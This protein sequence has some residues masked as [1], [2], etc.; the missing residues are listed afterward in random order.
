M[1]EEIKKL[2]RE[3]IN[4]KNI[5]KY[6]NGEICPCKEIIGIQGI[7]DKLDFQ[8]P[9]AW[10]GDL[11]NKEIVFI[12]SNPSID[13][14][15]EYP[16]GKWREEDVIDFF[17]NR[18]N[19]KWT[20]NNKTLKKDGTFALKQVNFWNRIENRLN[21]IYRISGINKINKIGKDFAI[22]EIVRCKSIGENGITPNIIGQCA[23]LY[24][25][26]TLKAAK[27]LKILIVVGSVA[28][29][30]F[31]NKFN[32]ENNFNTVPAYFYGK[33]DIYGKEIYLIFIPHT[34]ARGNHKITTDTANIEQLKLKE[35][36]NILEEIENHNKKLNP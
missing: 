14:E 24:L 5:D 12:S 18:F 20:K 6:Y 4:C 32:L 3:L 28:R 34:N 36:K 31:I 23:N 25:E 26:K 11:E 19:G 2:M 17:N 22:F 15:E 13:N 9:E 30:Y 29:N 8:L 1:D 27:S 21:D 16:T 35:L 7:E 10:N 33:I